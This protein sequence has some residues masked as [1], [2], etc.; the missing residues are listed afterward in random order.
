[1]SADFHF[2]D[3]PL[4]GSQGGA[5]RAHFFA[6]V[7]RLRANQ[8]VRDAAR[9]QAAHIFLRQVRAE[10]GEALEEDADMLW[11]DADPGSAHAVAHLPTALIAEPLDKSGDG[12]W[13]A[14]VDLHVRN[15]ACA[16]GVWH[17]Q[18]H[19]GWL[20]CGALDTALQRQVVGDAVLECGIDE[21]LYGP[22]GSGASGKF[23]R[24]HAVA[25]QSLEDAMEEV[26]VGAAETVDGLLGVSDHEERA[27]A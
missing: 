2:C 14:T 8:Q 3:R 5:Q 10:I 19:D 11:T 12:V 23:T 16:I 22:I 26:G 9:L 27:G 15:I 4:D 24:A 7:E 21:T 1:M 13:R 25:A 17:G 20:S 6:A 18:C